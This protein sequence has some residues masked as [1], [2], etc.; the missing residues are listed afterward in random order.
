MKFFLT[1]ILLVLLFSSLSFSQSKITSKTSPYKIPAGVKASDYLPNTILVKVKPNYRGV[2]EKSKININPLDVVLSKIG[3]SKIIKSYPNHQAPKSSTNKYGQK[4]VDLSL[5]YEITFNPD[6]T[7]EKAINTLL[8]TGFFEYVEPYFLP[9]LMYSPND[10]M[11][12]SQYSLSIMKIYQAWDICK[13]DTNVVIGISDTGNDID[14]PDL[15]NNIKYNYDDPIDGVDNDNDGFIDNYRGWDL[16]EDDNNPQVGSSSHGIWVGGIACA[17]TDNGIGVCGVGFKCKLLPCKITNASGSLTKSYQSIIYLADHGANIINC[18]WGG[19]GGM[20]QYGQDV[21]NYAVINNNCL[22]IA[23]CGNNGLDAQYFPA[24]YDNVLSVAATNSSDGKWY[25][26]ATSASTYNE[27]VDICAPGQGVQS[28]DNGGAYISTWGGTSFASP[29]V[30]GAAAIVKSFYPNFTGQ[31][32]GEQLK[33]TADVIDTMQTNLP[34]LGKLGTGRVNLYKAL[35]IFNKPSVDLSS[36]I[37]KDKNDSIFISGDTLLITAS[38]LNY[39]APSGNVLATLSTNSSYVSIIDGVSNYGV[40]NTMQT[41]TNQSDVFKVKI[42]NLS[43]FNEVIPFSITYQDTSFSKTYNFNVIINTDYVNLITDKIS[44]SITSIG[45]IGYVDNSRTIGLGYLYDGSYTLTGCIGLALGNMST[46][47]SDAVYG[48]SGFSAMDQDFA[49]ISVAKN[50]LNPIRADYQITG[51]MNDSVA[52]VNKVGVDVDYTILGWDSTECTDFIIAEYNIKNNNI[53]PITNLFIGMYADWD[54]TDSDK[55]KAEFD[56]ENSM[57]YIYSLTSG[58]HYGAIKMLTEGNLKHYAIDNDGDYGSI[59]ISDGFSSAEKWTALRNNRNS[60]G[61]STTHPD[62]NDVSH[63]VSAGPFAIVAGDSI[64]IAFAIITGT[65]LID[66][67]QSAVN[68]QEKYSPSVGIKK[69]NTEIKAQVFPNPANNEIQI[70]INNSNQEKIKVQ[71]FDN[72]GKLQIEKEI[73]NNE[74]IN[75]EQLA[76]GVYM[77]SIINGKN[78]FKNKLVIK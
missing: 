21:V 8:P 22:V 9:E 49:Y 62:G 61:I 13:G 24:S 68:A 3:A 10:P 23:A 39:L 25:G 77:V 42:N 56:A 67:K 48:T 76:K 69:N 7:V 36:V 34:Y 18:S 11:K 16:G 59:N 53:N 71:I 14:H 60:A 28:T 58:E 15:V 47:I 74:K 70:A 30:A 17:S 4:L 57:G 27:K 32:V 31:Q 45:R 37:V 46:Q 19:Q 26:N 38:L 6:Y 43:N 63:M 52:G 20:G 73:E 35:T 29:N 55:N 41:K 66:I 51:V 2:C 64:K 1:N 33:A 72:L 12:G 5:I 65:S 40:I 54:I 78:I 44:T 50:I 75:V